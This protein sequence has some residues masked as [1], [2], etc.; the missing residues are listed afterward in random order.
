MKR[1]LKVMCLFDLV[2][3]PSGPELEKE[4]QTDDWITEQ[5][6]L[7]TL[8]ELG[9]DVS[10]FALYDDPT[11]LIHRLKDDPPDVV[12]NLVEQFGGDRTLDKSVAGILD[13]L[14]IPYTGAGVMGLG[15]ARDK[16]LAKKVLTY[17][18]VRTPRFFVARRNRRTVVPK[19][20]RFPMFVKP[21]KED[22]SEGIS[23]DSFVRRKKRMLERIEFVH[24]NFDCDAIV[25][26]Y[27]EGTEEALVRALDR[28]ADHD[29]QA[30]VGPE[31]PG[32]LGPAVDVRAGDPR[33]GRARDRQD[34]QARL[35]RAAVA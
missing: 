1:R 15:I 21:T 9:H 22:A 5:H 7:Y 31:G 30:Q 23:L 13:M 11:T 25:E 10:I 20:M 4:L 29:V 8:E 14:E 2:E 26:E 35:P 16:A 32:A 19:N 27:I 12:F 33:T 17:H 34:F 6:V 28:A 24:A 18:H 3:P